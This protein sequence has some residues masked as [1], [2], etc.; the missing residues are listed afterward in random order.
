MNEILDYL[1]NFQPDDWFGISLRGVFA[2]LFILWVALVIWVARD[3]VGRSK[4]L[5]FQVFVILLAIVLN[6]FGLLIYLIVRPQKT[7]VEKY[8]EDLEHKALVE[9]EELCP[10][11]E[12]PLPLT[13]QFCPH[14][15]EEARKHCKKC[16][17]LVSKKW[18][19]CAYCGTKKSVQKKVEDTK[20]K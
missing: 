8:H 3:S 18:S 15:A 5:V 16:H 17:K 9:N 7:L 20:S 11:C 4:N 12:K 1:V 10:K 2:Y 6:I 19:A 14:C 13:F